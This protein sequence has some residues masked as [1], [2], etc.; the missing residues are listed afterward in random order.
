[1]EVQYKNLTIE[2][3]LAC[4]GWHCDML[5][6]SRGFTDVVGEK[7]M[8]F[9]SIF[10]FIDILLSWSPFDHSKRFKRHIKNIVES[11]GSSLTTTTASCLSTCVSQS[12]YISLQ[13][14]KWMRYVKEKNIY[15]FSPYMNSR[16]C[17]LFHLS[18]HVNSSLYRLDG[19]WFNCVSK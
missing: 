11:S 15:S 10:L 19:C 13:V 9:F 7:K 14:S 17:V 16:F 18:F 2:A 12:S 3:I 6:I 4:E 8:Q 5:K 1:M